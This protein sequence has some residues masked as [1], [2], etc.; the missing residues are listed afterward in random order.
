M[1][2]RKTERK[3]TVIELKR[4][5]E[6]TWEVKEKES[7]SMETEEQNETKRKKLDNVMEEEII[8]KSSERWREEKER[9]RK[10]RE[11]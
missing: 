11:T 5:L 3:S 9:E 6:R 2:E 10:G 4:K 1:Q 8:I 7:V